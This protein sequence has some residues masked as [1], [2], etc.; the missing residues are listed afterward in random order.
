MILVG[1]DPLE[2]QYAIIIL[3]MFRGNEP[4]ARDLHEVIKEDSNRFKSFEDVK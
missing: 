2:E 4:K 1:Y 3:L